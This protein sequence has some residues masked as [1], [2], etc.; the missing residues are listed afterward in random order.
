MPQ[1]EG[2]AESS[3]QTKGEVSHELEKMTTEVKL[4]EG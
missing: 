4:V 1:V 3:S 2:P